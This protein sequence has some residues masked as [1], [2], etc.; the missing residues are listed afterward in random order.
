MFVKIKSEFNIPSVFTPNG[1]G[2][3]DTWNITGL[4]N[5]TYYSTDIYN[6]WGNLL[7]IQNNYNTDAWDGTRNG[8][9]LPVGTYY[10]LLKIVGEENRTGYVTLMR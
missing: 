5:F 3:N 2:V 7:Y 1:D 4:D 6:R 9:N 8:K 10:Y